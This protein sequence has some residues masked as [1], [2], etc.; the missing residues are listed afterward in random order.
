[1]E[2]IAVDTRTWE[3]L[4]LSQGTKE[5]QGRGKGTLGLILGIQ[6]QQQGIRGSNRASGASKGLKDSLQRYALS[7]CLCSGKGLT[8]RGSA[9]R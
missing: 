7:T 1:M 2:G 3:E 4:P 8:R 5:I 6:G 9:G